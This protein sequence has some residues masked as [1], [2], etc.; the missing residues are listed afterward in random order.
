MWG[1]ECHRSGSRPAIKINKI[2]CVTEYVGHRRKVSDIHER[3]FSES[4]RLI[5]V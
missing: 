4:P 1:S 5:A 3:Q 2:L